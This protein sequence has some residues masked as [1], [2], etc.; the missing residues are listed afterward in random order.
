MCRCPTTDHQPLDIPVTPTEAIEMASTLVNDDTPRSSHERSDTP[1]PPT[2]S[3]PPL[4]PVKTPPDGS[5]DQPDG[6]RDQ[7]DGSHDQLEGSHDQPDASHDQ[8]EGSHDH[9]HS[10]HDHID[11]SHNYTNGSHDHTKGSHDGETWKE[12]PLDAG[13]YGNSEDSLRSSEFSDDVDAIF[14]EVDQSA[15]TSQLNA[16]VAMGMHDSLGTLSNLSAD[17]DTTVCCN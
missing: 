17:E 6:S 14:N 10:S 4:S 13:N 15:H 7:P 8:L 16:S 11:E 1:P 9:T 5:H 3:P 12:P 2:S